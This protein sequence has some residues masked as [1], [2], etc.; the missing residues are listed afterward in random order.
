MSLIR[1]LGHPARVILLAYLT[2]AAFG[3]GLLMLPISA[4]SG[5]SAP[6]MDASFTAVSA[7]CITGLVTVDTATYW[8]PFGHVVI[9]GL[10][11]VAAWASSPSG[12]SSRCS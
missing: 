12:R 5:T 1:V 11:Q 6:L 9:I 2:A 4:S 10:I 3:T 8:T 7:L